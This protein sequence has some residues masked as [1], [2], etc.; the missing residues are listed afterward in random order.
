MSAVMKFR[1]DIRLYDT[2]LFLRIMGDI[3]QSYVI[4]DRFLE[5]RD[6]HRF[7]NHISKELSKIKTPQHSAA[8]PS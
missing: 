4:S 2:R 7:V 8:L 6:Q 1:G 5:E 3:W